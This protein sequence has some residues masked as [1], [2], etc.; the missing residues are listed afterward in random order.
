MLNNKMI[1]GKMKGIIW[2]KYIENNRELFEKI[3]K[4]LDSRLMKTMQD[5]SKAIIAHRNRGQGM[6]LSELGGWIAGPDKAPVGVKRITRLL[7]SQNWDEKEI[8]EHLWQQATEK[9]MELQQPQET[10]YVIWDESVIEKPESLKSERL[11]AVRS[12]KAVRLKRIKPGYFNP[13]GGRPV[14][15]PGFNWL[16]ILVL[17]MK[18]TPQLAHLRWWTTRG[19][20]ARKKREEEALV[21]KKLDQMSVKMVVHIWDFSQNRSLLYKGFS[22]GFLYS[23]V[24]GRFPTRKRKNS[25]VS[26]NQ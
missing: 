22:Q 4:K 2:G 16:Q 21:L 14:F 5:L 12:S 1:Q 7:E 19:P 11:C 15:V 9:V 3:G 23:I 18:S 17:G 10:A 24:V 13:P 6:V 8:E 20:E 26:P 25:L